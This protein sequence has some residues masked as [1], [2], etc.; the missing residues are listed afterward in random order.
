MEEETIPQQTLALNSSNVKIHCNI[1][2]TLARAQTCVMSATE[3]PEGH[4]GI[5]SPYVEELANPDHQT[6]AAFICLYLHKFLG[7]TAESAGRELREMLSAIGPLSGTPWG[8]ELAHICWCLDITLRAQCTSRWMVDGSGSYIGTVILGAGYTLNMKDRSFSPQSRDTLVK[9]YATASPHLVAL[10]RIYS[11]MSQLTP[12]QR[13]S[14]LAGCDSVHLLR[15]D[16]LSAPLTA[17]AKDVVMAEL[18]KLFFP[19]DPAPLAPNASNVALCLNAIAN[20]SIRI[21]DLPMLPSKVFESRM[22]RVW[23][24]F[25]KIAPSFLVS[26][27]KQMDLERSF[28]VRRRGAGGVMEAQAVNKIGIVLKPIDDAVND[29]QQVRLK[30]EILNPH[31]ASMATRVSSDSLIRSFEKTACSNVVAALRAFCGITGV[32][33]PSGDVSGRKKKRDAGDDAGGPTK[34]IALLDF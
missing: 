33:G 7:P 13:A 6:L 14:A 16:L 17:H 1:P 28:E 24:A 21:N 4:H 15:I 23:S 2:T 9:D 11:Q 8:N 19:T 34:R 32:G 26:G 3:L 29:L 12:E 20:E 18:P 31:G 22:V 5:I 25:G 10:E 27:G 30:M